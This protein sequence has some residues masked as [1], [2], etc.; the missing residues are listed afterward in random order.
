MA[1]IIPDK[2][3][4]LCSVPIGNFDDITL[5]VLKA[6]NA[7]E[8]I[9]CE[10]FKPA[11]RLL[12]FLEID[13]YE[14]EFVP[15]KGRFLS[16]FNEN[17]DREERNYL[18]QIVFP[19][20]SRIAYISDCGSPVFEDPGHSILSISK[21]FFVEYL[22]GVTSLS[23]LM[24]FLP[25]HIKR[26]E[27]LGFLSRKNEVRRQELISIKKADKPVFLMETPYRMHKMLAE[28]QENFSDWKLLFGYKLSHREEK[29]LRGTVSS[30][31]HQALQM[32]QA[33][34]VLFLHH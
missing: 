30:V 7:A 29:V 1:G 20:V 12:K 25:E 16:S 23:A 19:K 15:G 13:F 10:E 9:V 22:P 14:G 26:F 4:K 32:E 2:T 31:V 6:L 21:G 28:L 18:Q 8:V 5:R 33:E 17:T 24:M 11:R 3:L 27:V 34:F